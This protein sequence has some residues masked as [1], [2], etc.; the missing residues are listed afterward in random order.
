[1]NLRFHFWGKGEENAIKQNFNDGW[2]P[3]HNHRW[4]FSSK[5]IKGGLD[6]KEYFDSD[7]RVR[8]D[9]REEA[10]AEKVDLNSSYKL[11]DVCAVPT[12]Q[13]GADY[14]IFRTG[15]FAIIGNYTRKYMAAGNSYYL[16]H[17]IPHQVKPEF[18]TCTLLLMDPPS[19]LLASEIFVDSNDHFQEEFKLQDLSFEETQKYLKEFLGSLQ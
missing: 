2:E 3:I 11:Y 18:D 17:R 14:R 10:E 8:F 1:L 12:R 5:V 9:I 13:E 6:S 7:S 16:D 19:K 4:N 15:K